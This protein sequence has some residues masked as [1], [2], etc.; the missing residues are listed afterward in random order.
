MSEIAHPPNGARATVV[1][2]FTAGALLL[3][4]VALSSQHLIPL[5]G[6]FVPASLGAYSVLLAVMIL[7][8]EPPS[9][10]FGPANR[11]TLIRAVFV[12]LVGGVIVFPPMSAAE[13]TFVAWITVAVAALAGG[14]DAVD[15][16]VA[17]RH[18][19]T[20]A[21]GARFDMETD[22]LFVLLLAIL[23]W[24]FDKAGAWIIAAGA[25]R[26]GFALALWL[27]PHL[28]WPLPPSPRRQAVCVTMVL[29][30]IVCLAPPVGPAFATPIAAAALALLIWSFAIDAVWIWRRHRLSGSPPLAKQ[31]Q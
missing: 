9:G 28:R 1:I 26:Y 18:K 16:W 15:G 24:R 2:H 30:L 5:S 4:V 21:F 3:T 19:V 29:A 27:W 14:L 12:C 20:S 23:V 17:R 11:V 22:S 8:A 25:L 13:T 10:R 7:A 31:Q 6:A